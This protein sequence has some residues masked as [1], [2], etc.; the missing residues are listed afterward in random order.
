M[1]T[2]YLKVFLFLSVFA[3]DVFAHSAPEKEDSSHN[4][5][6]D[7]GHG[8]GEGKNLDKNVTDPESEMLPFYLM[9][10]FKRCH[11]DL[12]SFIIPV[13]RQD[14]IAAQIDIRIVIQGKDFEST[15]GLYRKRFK[16]TDFLYKHLYFLFDFSYREPFH[17][18]FD[19]MRKNIFKAL[20]SID[21]QQLMD[22][23]HIVRFVAKKTLTPGAK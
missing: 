20:K 1:M 14:R 19:P 22:Q 10:D 6:N 21:D 13:I 9:K 5:A 16:I 11:L 17:P 3:N 8:G 12:P 18:D 23:V 15:I 4:G 2:L 7:S